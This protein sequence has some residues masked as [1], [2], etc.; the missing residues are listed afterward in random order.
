MDVLA[1]E[2]SRCMAEEP[3]DNRRGHVVLFNRADTELKS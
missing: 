2:R 1:G 3:G